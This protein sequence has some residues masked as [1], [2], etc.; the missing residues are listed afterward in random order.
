MQKNNKR[1]ISITRKEKH[2]KTKKIYACECGSQYIGFTSLYL[3]FQKKHNRNI[4]IRRGARNRRIEKL[5]GKTIYTYYFSLTVPPE[6]ES[7][8]EDEIS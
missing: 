3:H 6:N 8:E 4:S 5:K 7:F 2:L 1:R